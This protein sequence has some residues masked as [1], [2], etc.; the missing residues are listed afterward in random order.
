MET[1][2]HALREVGQLAAMVVAFADLYDVDG[3]DVAVTI[4][5]DRPPDAPW[6]VAIGRR[7]QDALLRGEGRSLAAALA[8]LCA[9]L[10]AHVAAAQ[11]RLAAAEAHLPRG[12]AS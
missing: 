5:G 7:D 12:D 4:L 2:E 10:R 3:A 8:D 9:H 6:V 11:A 1:H